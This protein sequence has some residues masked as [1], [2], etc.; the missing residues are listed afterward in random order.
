[1][2]WIP[3]P[4]KGDLRAFGG[5]KRGLTPKTYGESPREGVTAKSIATSTG[6]DMPILD[7][8][9]SNQQIDVTFAANINLGIIFTGSVAYNETGYWLDAMAYTDKFEEDPAEDGVIV[10]ERFGVGLRVLMRVQTI[11][12][13]ASLNYGLIGA[14][15]DIRNATAS[16]EIDS[17]GLGAGAL[18]TILGGIAQ[19]GDLTSDTFYK[20]NSVV[21]KSLVDYILA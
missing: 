19:G 16:Y 7:T 14:A 3:T 17:F 5:L 6:L 1:M 9:V 10:A 2:P 21:L 15:L 20:I 13:Q 12:G 11:N 4:S 8:R 18:N